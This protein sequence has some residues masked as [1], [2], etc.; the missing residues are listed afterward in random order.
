MTALPYRLNMKRQMRNYRLEQLL[1][2][3]LYSNNSRSSNIFS[4]KNVIVFFN[5]CHVQVR[6]PY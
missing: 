3:M 6:Q 5:F 2:I 1:L 4:L